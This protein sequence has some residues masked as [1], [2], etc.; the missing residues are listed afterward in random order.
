M[1]KDRLVRFGYELVEKI[2]Q[3]HGTAIEVIDNTAKT[4]EQEVVEDLVQIITVFSCKLQ[5]KRSKKT[6]QII[7]ELTS[8]DIGEESQIDSNA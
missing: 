3:L 4:E 8:D 6:K 7:K 5:G 2:Y 1:H